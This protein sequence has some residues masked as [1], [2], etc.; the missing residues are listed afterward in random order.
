MESANEC[1]SARTSC[2]HP[3]ARRLRWVTTPK[4]P[5]AAK[6]EPLVPQEIEQIKQLTAL[7]NAMSLVRPR[8]TDH[9]G[10]SVAQAEVDFAIPFLDEDIPLYLDPFLLW[11]SPSQQDQSLHINLVIC[12]NHL[13]S[14]IQKGRESEAVNNLIAASECDE[15][16]FGVSARRR[17]KRIG[18]G[19]AKEILDLFSLVPEYR[20]S[21]FTHFEE[22]QLYVD[23]ISKDRISDIACNFLKS[24]LIDFTMDQ[25]DEHGIPLADVRLESL[26]DSKT[27]RFDTD[28]EVQLPVMPESGKPILL[29]PKRWL[30][31]VPWINF[32]DYFATSCPKD[33][34]VNRQGSE[35]RV[36]VLHYNRENY[37]MVAE[38]VQQKERTAKDCH[39]DPLFKQIPVVSARRK[40]DEIR[41]LPTGTVDKAARK[42]EDAVAQ[43]LV[44]MLYPHLD[45]AATQSRS[46]GGSTIQD[47]IF[48]NNRSVDFLQ[49]I[50][51]DYR[52]R[53]LV[54]EMKNVREVER[55]HINQLNRY[56]TEEFGAFGVLV[57]RNPF[58]R[59]MF[60]NT[61]ALWSGQ[62]RCIIGLTDEDLELM[63]EVFDSKQ[64]Q[65]IEVLKKKYV[66]FQ[67]VC[68]S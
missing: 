57:T 59:A 37:G 18:A 52:S 9:H 45:F 54:M 30:R 32:D 34:V 50:L 68:P 7:Q 26:Y 12:F 64:R 35:D 2:E 21:G 40:L 65:P 27:Q 28:V 67:R 29:V 25:C 53:Q 31:H 62:R 17:G 63:V 44:S 11:R 49:E 46:E 41:K 43:L 47:L 19:M 36:Q 42:Y 22:I 6:D 8:F 58:T 20:R 14:L 24:F 66:E 15:V 4:K 60:R 10:I 13:G 61:V 5:A 56:L 38:Y 3:Q 16:G 33:D 55:E 51:D 39:N 1:I 48:Y 23:G